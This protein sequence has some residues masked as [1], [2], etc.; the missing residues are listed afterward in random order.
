MSI[1][2]SPQPAAPATST[3]SHIPPPRVAHV[4]WAQ[5]IARASFVQHVVSIAFGVCAHDIAA[6]TRRN[7]ATALARQVAMYLTHI[8]YEMSLTRVAQAFNRDRT[9]VTHACHLIEDMRDDTRFDERLEALSEYLRC[10]PMF[11]RGAR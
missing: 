1:H 2:Q 4:T 10:A 7:A 8:A 5:D 11:G 6:S 3:R 9:T